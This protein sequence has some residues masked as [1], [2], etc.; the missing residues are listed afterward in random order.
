MITIV[1]KNQNSPTPYRIRLVTTCQVCSLFLGPT[2]KIRLQGQGAA[3]YVHTTKFLT[4]FVH[5]VFLACFWPYGSVSK[6]CYKLYS[7]V[8]FLLAP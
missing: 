6:T 5:Y 2:D 1:A 8:R 3:Y 4:I 7:L